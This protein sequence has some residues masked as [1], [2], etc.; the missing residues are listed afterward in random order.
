MTLYAQQQYFSHLYW[1]CACTMRN[2]VIPEQ[3]YG[4]QSY[5]RTELWC[6]LYEQADQLVYT[7]FADI[8]VLQGLL[9]PCKGHGTPSS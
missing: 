9:I 8:S 4:Y 7:C 1:G 2:T 3:R 6:R 5:C